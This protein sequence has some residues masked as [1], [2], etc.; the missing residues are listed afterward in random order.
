M[1][2]LLMPETLGRHLGAGMSEVVYYVATSLDGYIA[3][4]DGGVE[5]LEP[6]ESGPEDYGY[7]AFYDSVDAVLLGSRTYEQS[8]SFGEWAY[9]G[10]PC[11]VFSGRLD[12]PAPQGVTVT[13]RSPFEVV[14]ELSERGIG[15]AWLVGGGS[16]AASFRDAGLITELIVSIMPVILGG[17][18]PLFWAAGP[19]TR[20]HLMDSTVYDDGVIQ[21]VYRLADDA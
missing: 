11:W 16:L 3:T 8:L 15:R 1:A 2:P 7:S 14:A 10:K 4:P 17:G 20:L 21:L 13:G 19:Q 5:W 6:F 12:S 9:P 18:V